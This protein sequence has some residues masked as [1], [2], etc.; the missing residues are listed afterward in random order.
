LLNDTYVVVSES[1][2]ESS[3]VEVQPGV[4]KGALLGI[5]GVQGVALSVLV[6]QVADDSTAASTNPS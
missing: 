6:G 4:D 5:L 1:L 2:I 3:L